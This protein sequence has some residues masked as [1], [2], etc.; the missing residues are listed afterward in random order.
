MI[1]N[2]GTSKRIDALWIRIKHD[3]AQATDTKSVHQKKRFIIKLPPWIN[4]VL[5]Y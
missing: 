1:T 2:P 4:N 3:A 5:F